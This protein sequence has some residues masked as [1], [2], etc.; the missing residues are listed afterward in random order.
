MNEQGS[1]GVCVMK[2]RK[3]LGPRFDTMATCHKNDK[4]T[5]CNIQILG[6]NFGWRARAHSLQDLMW[7]L[8]MREWKMQEWK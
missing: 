2:T 4:T 5:T 8:K 1:C 6:I 7:G 3:N